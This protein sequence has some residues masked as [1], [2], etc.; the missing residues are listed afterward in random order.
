MG[1]AAC[2]SSSLDVVAAP[3]KPYRVPPG[4]AE[5]V[6]KVP[7][8]LVKGPVQGSTL[9][10]TVGQHQHVAQQPVA[11]GL[12]SRTGDGRRVVNGA[13]PAATLPA[14]TLPGSTTLGKG[15]K[16][17]SSSDEILEEGSEMQ[18]LQICPW[19]E[20]DED[21][22]QNF[23]LG[24]PQAQQRV[25]A[26]SDG[27]LELS[28]RQREA[29]HAW[30]RLPELIRAGA[31][32]P[33][34]L[35]A[36]P[37]SRTICQGLVGD[38]S[39]LSAL[40][41]LAEYERRFQ[42]PVLSSIIHPRATSS[43]D[44][45][46]SH[47]GPI[48]NESGQ[49]GCRLFL[50]GTTRKVVVDDQVPVR[51][52][53]KLLCAHSAIP[54][55]MW[56][57]LLEKSFVK[58]MGS[59]YDMQG[60][61]PGTDV[62]HLTGWVPETI[63]LRSE[64]DIVCG[65]GGTTSEPVSAGGRR[66]GWDEVFSEAYEGYHSGRCVVCV[67]TSELVDAAPD[68]EARR[69][70]HIEG[71]SVTTGLVS[72]HA[73]PVL[74]CR[75]LGK[76]RLLRLKNPWGR[77]RW[78][79]RFSPGDAAWSEALPGI[80][81]DGPQ[82]AKR[83]LVEALG[84]DDPTADSDVDDG[85]FWIEWEDMLR[86]FSHLYLCWAPRA[87]GLHQVE[88]HGRWDP[89]PQFS[90]C[91]LPDDTHITAFNPQ[92]LLRL[93]APPP[94]TDERGVTVWCL[95]SRHVRMRADISTKYV[96]VHIYRG[97]SRLC[98]PDAPLEQG[99][100]SNGEC[101][102]VKLYSDK[103]LGER[104]FVISVSQHAQK[105]LF[106]FTLQVYTTVPATLTAL[107]LLVP[108]NWISG[109]EDGCWH[110]GTAG[111]CSN[112]L[113]SFFTNPQWRFEVPEGGLD[114]LFVFLECPA[115]HS[116][117]VRLFAGSAARPESLRMARSSGAYR[118]GCCFLRVANL[119]AG[120]YI[121][122]VSTFRPGLIGTY[123][124]AWHAPKSIVL[125]PQPH[126]FALALDPPLTISARKVARG[127]AMRFRLTTREQAGSLASFR[128]Q[129]NSKDGAQPTLSF[130]RLGPGDGRGAQQQVAPGVE[131]LKESFAESFYSSS[132][133]VAV[134]IAPLDPGAAY[135][136]QVFVPQEGRQDEA[137][138]Y[139]TS[140]ACLDIVTGSPSRH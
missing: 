139:I 13:V 28:D 16:L 17:R 3:H 57:T 104:D 120:P 103:A 107:P 88:I 31:G 99:I 128:V 37:S 50:N 24:H 90:Q 38:C 82:G 66:A 114:N 122:V 39:F 85:H 87:L 134:L 129:S 79:G 62:F 48:Y 40:S 127:S 15:R 1:C 116:V 111:G 125:R 102:L 121:A 18:G 81:S 27:L 115:E 117:N 32:K 42:D 2:C 60:S 94:E 118:Q 12:A 58:I 96:A 70:G 35:E 131:L 52:D 101:A 21:V 6:V 98:C 74:D 45:G 137:D 92:F 23:G 7:G 5:S 86:H 43:R 108:R 80:V 56:V 130:F 97:G 75:Q 4:K 22:A 113:W 44:D 34:V 135:E 29:L 126:P 138:L 65:G 41:A 47:E 78:R 8:V 36:Q 133:C 63:P 76:H 14:K 89:N 105:S 73:Y 109:S 33:T 95:L 49:Y 83:R 72:R 59:S 93:N 55:E 19:D 25:F 100:Y 51:R 67:G 61:N 132:G 84:G 10:S 124:L 9:G 112:N 140:D 106:N 26:D 64:F 110:K 11:Q 30:R 91:C 53:G 119:T 123:R 71:V 69:L 20:E 136:L 54:K 68:A 77:V 46:T